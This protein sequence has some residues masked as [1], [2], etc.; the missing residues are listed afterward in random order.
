MAEILAPHSGSLGHANHP[1]IRIH[2]INPFH[3]QTLLLI[4]SKC[5]QYIGAGPLHRTTFSWPHCRA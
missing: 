2:Y 5:S 1:V 4:Q 3:A